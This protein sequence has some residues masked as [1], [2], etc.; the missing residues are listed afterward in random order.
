ME[1]LSSNFIYVFYR[2]LYWTNLVSPPAIQRALYDG[3][4]KIDLF[5]T[6]L[7]KP[8]PITIDHASGLLFWADLEEEVIEVSDLS[9]GNRHTLV[10]NQQIQ[11]VVGLAVFQDYLY[12]VDKDK[13]LIGRVEKQ[14]GKSLTIVQGRVSNLSDLH[15]AIYVTSADVKKHPCA[16]NNGNCSHI[17]IAKTNSLAQCSCPNHLVLKNDER[18]CAEKTTCQPDQFTCGRGNTVCIPIMWRC[19]KAT[20][21]ADKSDEMNCPAC[22]ATEYQCKDGK[23]IDED[24][25]CDGTPQCDLKDDEE[26][27]CEN[28]DQVKCKTSN[29]CYDRT[30][31]CDGEKDCEDNSDEQNCPPKVKTEDIP[32]FSAHYTV[33]IVVGVVA[34]V[35]IFIIVFACRR[36]SPDTFDVDRDMIML[37]KPLN[38][39]TD[40]TPQNTLNTRSKSHKTERP[41]IATTTLTLG[42]DSGGNVYDRNHVTGAS[43]SSSAVTQYPKETLNPPPSPVTDRSVCNIDYGYSTTTPTPSTVRSYKRHRR[44]HVP[45]PPTTPCSTDVC[46]D[47][48]PYFPQGYYNNSI[49]DLN[50]D[51]SDPYP[52]P[53]TPRSQYFSDELSCP[54]SPTT[55]R[56]YFNPYPPPPSPVANSD[57]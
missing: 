2:H 19:D 35:F 55:E 56:S 44:R 39:Q 53:P 11:T 26:S 15:A 54:D 32:K 42:S 37:T 6:G 22:S 29:K 33:A 45:P 4:E 12:W 36:K 48:E 9:G 38:P 43:S 18:N 46:E 50:Y 23:C 27:C 57:C 49:L 21:C 5:T 16:K 40:I 41:Q 3:T 31:K 17:C 13:K 25:V 1:F 24:L 14:T 7:G 20:D 28:K 47:S 52:P 10:Q 34:I 30:K 51:P 8:G